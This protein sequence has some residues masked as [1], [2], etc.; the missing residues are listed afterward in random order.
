MYFSSVPNTEGRLPLPLGRLAS[1]V[2]KGILEEI[3]VWGI[4]TLGGL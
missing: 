1:D 2:T 3:G 4:D